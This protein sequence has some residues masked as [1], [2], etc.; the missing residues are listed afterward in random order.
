[1]DAHA[2]GR[3]LLQRSRKV[4][5]EGE[6]TWDITMKSY[7]ELVQAYWDQCAIPEEKIYEAIE[8]TN[9]LADMVEEFTLDTSFKYPKLFDDPNKMLKD[10]VNQGVIDKN[11]RL[12]PNYSEYVDRIRYEYE[13]YVYQGAIDY[14]LLDMNIKDYGRSKDIYPGCSRGSVS[15]SLIAYLIGITE[16]DPIKEK[17]NFERFMSKE[18]VSLADVDSDF[19]PT[20]RETIKDYIYSMQK[21]YCADIITFNTV[22]LKGSIRDCARVIYNKEIPVSLQRKADSELNN[23]GQLTDWTSKEINKYM[24]DYLEIS[25]YVCENI[26]NDEYHMRREYP[27]LFEYVDIIQGTIVSVGTHPCGTVV[28]PIPL[29]EVIGLTTLKDST[30]P[31]TMLNMKEIDSLNFVKLDILGLDNQEIINETCK[32]AGIERLTPDNVPMD[33]EVWEA[34]ARDTTGVFQ[35]ESDSASAYIEKLFSSE[36]VAK[37]K[38]IHPNFKYID[39]FSVGNGAI[40][41]AGASYRNELS[42]GIF[43]DNGHEALNKFLAPTLGYLVYQ[44]QIIE[45]LNKFC[46]FTLGEADIVRR[47]FAKKTGTEE[48]ITR[49]K[50]GFIKTMKNEYGVE[51]SEAEELIN[52]FLQVIEDASD[53]LFSLNHAQAYSYIGYICGY[54]REKYPIEFYTVSLNQFKDNMDKTKKIMN[55]IKDKNIIIGQPT[56]GKSKGD[57]F[58]DKKNNT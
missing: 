7:D 33:N 51:E 25:N 1:N 18:R 57:Y 31:V 4:I 3:K 52:S 47:G 48:Y 50:A 53:Y 22:A 8:N 26:E 38:E 10:R 16:I 43:R 5:F 23:L 20:K 2:K 54:L 46:G 55:S 14:L 30:R 27:E 40:R 36:T 6:D 9:V 58:C 39:L 41:P 34:I 35:W 49:I 28:S 56:F 45:F 24:K 19:P 21:V 13:T 29:D 32:L 37:I 17:L 42:Q 11:I 15:G 12:Y 44:E